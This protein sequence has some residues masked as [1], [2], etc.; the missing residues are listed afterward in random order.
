[1]SNFDY[2][3]MENIFFQ[4]NIFWFDIFSVGFI[5]FV[6]EFPCKNE[7]FLLHSGSGQK[8]VKTHLFR[9]AIEM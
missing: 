4:L 7:A 5:S 2:K 6:G 8:V 1:M 9:T 3:S